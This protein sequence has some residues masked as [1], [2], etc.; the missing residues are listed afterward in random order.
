MRDYDEDDIRIRPTRRSRPR[1]KNKPRHKDAVE[2]IVTTVD[3]GRFGAELVSDGT[4][5]TAMKARALGHLRPVVGDRVRLAGDVSGVPGSLSRIVEVIPRT[6]LLMR[7]AD[8][9]TNVERPLVANADQLGVVVSAADPPPRQGFVDRALVAAFDAGIR[10]LIIVTKTDLADPSEFLR[11]Y[12]DLDVPWCG[13]R[14]GA[15]REV[16]SEVLTDRMTVLVGHSGVGKSTLVNALVPDAG[17]ATGMVND[18]T[19]R[20]RHTSTSAVLLDL[21]FGGRIV[22]TPGVRSFGLNHVQP[23]TVLK[24]F[25]D[26][27]AG[28]DSCPRGCTHQEPEC[29]LD[30]WVAQG[31]APARRLGSLRRILTTLAEAPEHWEA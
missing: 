31:H 14:R 7:T 10:P 20:G 18:V 8:D 30:E 5:L 24:A 25:E 23:D 3:R 2:A 15:A 21:P 29:A 11:A 28:A 19:G 16:L 9:V 6:T 27:A 17:R 22:D 26:L 12:A 1:S 4:E 13:V